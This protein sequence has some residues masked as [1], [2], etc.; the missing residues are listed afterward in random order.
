VLGHGVDE[1]EMF[2]IAP[3]M[4]TKE[5]V[6]DY[7]NEGSCGERLLLSDLDRAGFED[8][9]S[10]RYRLEPYIESFAGF[11]SWKSRKVLE[12][13]IGL[14]A[15]HQRFVAAGADT[16]GIDLTPRAVEIC[17][18]RLALFGLHSDLRIGDAEQLPF[19]EEIFDLVWAWGVIHHTPDTAAAIREMQ[20]VLKPGG[21]VK[22][23]IYHSRSIVGLMLWIRYAL[24]RGR[25]WMKMRDIYS[26]YLES[27]G[28]KAYS[29]AQ[30]RDLFAG[31]SDLQIETVL[32]HGDLLTSKAGQRHQGIWLTIARRFM[33]R[34]LISR[35]LPNWGLFMLIEAKKPL[36]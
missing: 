33:P 21:M 30:A 19:P 7:W 18:L 27:P 5:A 4:A 28:T 14:G 2:G 9:A 17:R 35:I 3:R 24:L 16:C 15:D 31:F 13:G 25:P 6:R 23:M 34:R 8:Q 36:A 26:R 10:E 29:V 22:V 32:T 11:E 20:R 12:V 1:L